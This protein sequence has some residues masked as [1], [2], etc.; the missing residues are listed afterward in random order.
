MPRFGHHRRLPLEH[1][2]RHGH[3]AEAAPDALPDVPETTTATPEAIPAPVE[4]VSAPV[5]VL[6][7]ESARA[8][9]R[10]ALRSPKAGR[11]ASSKG[12]KRGAKK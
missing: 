1:H 10:D 6:S 11:R 8:K 5:E 3:H 7:V 4:A 2:H 12:K 9:R